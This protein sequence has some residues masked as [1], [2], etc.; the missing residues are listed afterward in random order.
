MAFP[1]TSRL[2]ET[3]SELNQL[4]VMAGETKMVKSQLTQ[5]CTYDSY[6]QAGQRVGIVGRTGRDL[7][8]PKFCYI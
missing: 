7:V 5:I 2:S 8:T 3:K 1:L 4:T 6:D